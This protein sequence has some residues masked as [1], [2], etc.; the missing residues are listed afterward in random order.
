MKKHKQLT[1]ILLLFFFPLINSFSQTVTNVTITST[2]GQNICIKED[3]LFPFV[4]EVVV[5]PNHCPITSYTIKWGDGSSQ[6]F[7]TPVPTS[8][9]QQKITHSHTYNFKDFITKCLTDVDYSLEI[10]AINQI[11]CNPDPD[12]NITPITFKNL[13]KARFSV[14][15]ICIGQSTN[16]VNSSCPAITKYEWD[17]GDGSPKG[18]SSTHTYTAAGYYNVTLKTTNSCGTSQP[19]V[20]NIQVI[21]KAV[22]AISDSGYVV[23][24]RDT[25]ICLGNGGIL[26]LDGTVSTNATTLRWDIPGVEGVDW[27]YVEKTNRNSPTPKIKFKKTGSYNI[28]LTADNPCSSPSIAYCP[29]K[30]IDVPT[31]KITAQ[32]DVCEPIRYKLVNPI[33]D[34][35]YTLNGSPLGLTEEKLLSES[36]SPY[37]VVARLSNACGNQQ[38]SDTFFVA[39]AKPIKI[40]S[41]PRDTTVCVGS[42][43]LPLKV[44]IQGG[45]WDNNPNIQTQGTNT[46]FNPKTTGA[47]LIKYVKGTGKCRVADSVRINVAGVNITINDVDVCQGVSGVKLKSSPSGGNWTSPDCSTC[48]IG[49]SITLTG[50]SLSTIKINYDVTSNVGCKASASAQIRIGRPKADFSIKDGCAGNKVQPI[51]NSTGATTYRWF[52]GTTQVATQASP[53]LDI[54]SGSTS[55]K[56]IAASG[57]C[58]DSISKVVTV[59][60]PPSAISIS[61]NQTTGC[62][63]LPVS[64]TVRQAE[65]SDLTYSWN[66]GDGS[67]N[68][69]GYKIAPHV[70]NNT[71]KNNLTYKTTLSLENSCGKQSASIEIIVKPI[72][73]S[74]IGV[75]STIVR[76]NPA[77]IKFSNRSSG[78]EKNGVWN[79]GDGSADVISKADTISHV[80]INNDS[81]IRTYSVS[82]LVNNECGTDTYITKIQVYPTNI[83]ALINVSSAEACPGEVIHFKDASVPKP[84]GWVWDFGDGQ[85]SILENPEH[86]FNRANTSFVVKLTARTACSA[87]TTTLT[88]KTNKL[89]EGD[90]S[91]P[92]LV[93]Q[94]QEVQIK[95]L[96]DPSTVSGV[97]WNFGDGSPIDSLNYAPIHKF[98]S[99]GGSLVVKMTLVGNRKTCTRDITKNVIINSMANPKAVFSADSILCIA[100]PINMLNSSTNA[101]EYNWIVSNGK[102]FQGAFPDDFTL[103]KGA[104]TISLVATNNKYCKDSTGHN[105]VVS[106]C[107]IIVPDAFSPNGDGDNDT[108]KIF[109]VEAFPHVKVSVFDR[110][111]NIIFHSEGY[112]EP[113]DG[114]VNGEVLPIGSYPYIID[115]RPKRL[116]K[117][118][119]LLLVR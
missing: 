25:V 2:V 39:Q 86:I 93:C 33:A 83:K 21:N 18:S 51:N 89:P 65:R 59:T 100:E 6:T 1:F 17:Y 20:Q 113:F 50:I 110:W 35:S 3:T 95:N 75:D 40:L 4:A 7:N 28:K 81:T 38:V 29:H 45:A 111:G 19:F 91:V 43:L 108:W 5:P 71:S 22:A 119:I 70:F 104:Y 73:K 103:E 82:L 99:N 94:G 32:P 56:L 26:R 54:P 114:K 46:F 64:F 24:G 115:P 62:A 85:I 34:A 96:T 57:S 12:R 74:E 116:V 97:R 90:F 102:S 48:I 14:S 112:K 87:N 10:A 16:F 60:S 106:N 109:G 53:S 13:P 58:M 118:G 68:E 30:V 52:V 105:F 41:L 11:S 47:Y 76:C 77:R 88:I 8:S 72:V 42:S 44:D 80:F 49:D 9:T 63:P 78:S 69:K 92:P 79:F 117:S 23:A 36:T 101:D 15:T 107:E 37:I 27:E 98:N 67:P 61:A 31:L 84:E 55:I 66:F